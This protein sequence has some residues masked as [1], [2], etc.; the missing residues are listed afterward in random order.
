MSSIRI[1]IKKAV[2]SD[3]V[4]LLCVSVYVLGT[5][6][7]ASYHGLHDR[8][9]AVMYVIPAVL[10]FFTIGMLFY[11][12]YI[13]YVMIKIRPQKLFAY[14]RLELKKWLLNYQFVRGSV[15]YVAICIFL[16]AMTSF[17][18]LIPDI[19]S[20]S[21]DPALANF[22]RQLHGGLA[23]WEIIQPL[24]GMP[25]IS[26]FIDII[27]GAW[28]VVMLT[29]VFWFIFISKNEQLRRQ[30]LLTYILSWA[31]NGTVLAVF[32]SSVGPAF[33]AN[34]YPET[35]NP[36]Q[37]LMAYLNNADA[38][39]PLVALEAQKMLWE[40]YQ[41]SALG[42]AGGISSM[43]SMHVSIAFL[44][45]LACWRAHYFAPKVFGSIFLALI[46]IGS[47]HLGW[48]YAIDGYLSIVTTLM[49]WKLS[50][51]LVS[52]EITKPVTCEVI[53]RKT[54]PA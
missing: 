51:Y 11:A 23:P 14:L 34:V 53:E 54:D 3:R 4:F 25:V 26:H 36:Y 1:N 19:N 30:F 27:Y 31:I 15:N 40:F 46:L 17:K 10:Q 20:F 16:S 43:P 41:S 49:I 7:F 52:N 6:C 50:A 39:Y 21:W 18:S 22:D 5:Y 45:L 8:F 12:F 32:F 2:N 28:F 38:S 24:V 13:L 42:T 33:F 37:G 29:A 44:I 48:H 47:V 35:I 9:S